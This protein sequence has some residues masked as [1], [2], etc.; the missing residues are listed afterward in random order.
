MVREWMFFA[1]QYVEAASLL[2]DSAIADN[3]A[4]LQLSGHAVECAL[5]AF[6]LTTTQSNP[7]T[8]DL[9]ALGKSAEDAGCHVTEIQAIA[10]FQL[11]L[12]YSMDIA[13]NT[14]Y[15]ARYPTRDFESKVRATPSHDSVAELVANV[16][17]QVENRL[18]NLRDDA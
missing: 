4:K 9:L 13:T 8:H 6:L 16:L 2:D 12:S 17:T 10:V 3:V 11:S 1:Q 18:T 5:K 7:K 15:K 14:R